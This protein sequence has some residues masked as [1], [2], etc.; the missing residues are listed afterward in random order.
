MA[1]RALRFKQLYVLARGYLLF[2]L[3]AFT[4]LNKLYFI[5]VDVRIIFANFPYDIWTSIDILVEESFFD[6]EKLLFDIGGGFDILVAH[7]CD[8][9]KLLDFR[10]G[11]GQPDEGQDSSQAVINLVF[12]GG[13]IVL[14]DAEVRV[15]D[16]GVDQLFV[17]LNRLVLRFV[18]GLVVRIIVELVRAVSSSYHVDYGLVPSVPELNGA[19]A[20]LV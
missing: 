4:V 3:D 16:P 6:Q 1:L 19:P 11:A 14:D 9:K 12:E 5:R 17:E 20:C 7:I 8:K 18:A 2:L 13:L 15:A 10:G